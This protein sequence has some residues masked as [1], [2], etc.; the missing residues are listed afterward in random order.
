MNET[1]I[2]ASVERD[3]QVAYDDLAVGTAEA[4]PAAPPTEGAAS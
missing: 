1:P 2:F 3:M 4:T